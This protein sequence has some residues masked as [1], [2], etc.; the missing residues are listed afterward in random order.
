[1]GYKKYFSQEERNLMKKVVYLIGAG[2]SAPLGLPVMSNFLMKS[3]D[4]FFANPDKYSHFEEVFNKIKTM[5]VI[6]NYY[7]ADLFNIE[8]ILSILEMEDYLDF[9]SDSDSKK[10][11]D[12]I[13]DVINFYTPEIKPYNN[14]QLP[15]NWYDFI[16]GRDRNNTLYGYFISNLLN[17]KIYKNTRNDKEIHGSKIENPKVDYSIIT[18]NY[19]LIFENCLAFLKDHYDISS[20]IG[21]CKKSFIYDDNKMHLYKLHGSIDDLTIVPPTWNKNNNS[22]LAAIWGSAKKIMEEA[23]HIRIL[24]Y[25]LPISDSYIKYLLKSSVLESR[26]LK[27]IDVINLDPSG[28]VKNRYDEFINFNYYRFVNGNIENYLRLNH[29]FHKVQ[30][31]KN[32]E[33]EVIKF[34]LLE[35]VHEKFIKERSN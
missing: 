27:T 34:D 13:I 3:K 24:G 14:G 17:L 2:F 7:D 20:N 31:R 9:K 10:F 6:K 32:N 19:D 5:S 28:I 25:S 1:M 30:R 18:L 4:Q 8:E 21:Y 11:I 35:D 26:H 29:D 33:R 15:G 22:D 23:N 12:Y 16:F